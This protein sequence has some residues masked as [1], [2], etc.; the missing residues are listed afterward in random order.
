VSSPPT[1]PI[2]TQIT[3]TKTYL[4]R[5]FEKIHDNER[6][7]DQQRLHLLQTLQAIGQALN[8]WGRNHNIEETQKEI[9]EAINTYAIDTII[10]GRLLALTRKLTARPDYPFAITPPLHTLL[11]AL[12][13]LQTELKDSHTFSA[14]TLTERTTNLRRQHQQFI[15]KTP[16]REWA[17]LKI[18]LDT[19]KKLE[20][21]KAATSSRIDR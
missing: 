12:Q 19:L 13:Q 8:S 14:Q 3:A 17:N 1:S 10:K 18:T 20:S 4:A 6:D 21:R 7:K 2:G 5:H 11:S 9:E 15:E 16:R